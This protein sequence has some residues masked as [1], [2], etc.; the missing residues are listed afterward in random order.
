MPLPLEMIEAATREG[1]ILDAWELAQKSGLPLRDWP[2]GNARRQAAILAHSL[3][4]HRLSN[5]LDWLNWRADRHQPNR[6]HQALFTRLRIVSGSR[7]LPEIDDFLAAHPEMAGRPPRGFP[8]H[9][10]KR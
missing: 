9:G 5:A 4:A 10:G 2:A 6:Y 8:L 7:L 3:G 1:R